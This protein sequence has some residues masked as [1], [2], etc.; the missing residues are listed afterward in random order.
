[1]TVTVTESKTE[2]L[3]GIL[4]LGLFVRDRDRDRWKSVHFGELFDFRLSEH[5]STYCLDTTAQ[6]SYDFGK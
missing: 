3:A 6:L 1:M 2:D 4:S 5:R